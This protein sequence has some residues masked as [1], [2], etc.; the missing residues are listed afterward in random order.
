MRDSGPLRR[1][2]VTVGARAS[3]SRLPQVA[4]MGQNRDVRDLPMRIRPLALYGTSLFMPASLGL[5]AIVVGGCDPVINIGGANFPGWLLCS[6]VGLVLAAVLRQ[7]FV[8][9]EIEPYMGP[10]V[11]IYPCLAVLIGCITWMVFFNRV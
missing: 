10:A 3:G 11:L 2:I 4:K 5:L 1:W 7:L 8:A 6:I 9:A